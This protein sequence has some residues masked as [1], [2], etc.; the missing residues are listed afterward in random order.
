M[1][2]VDHKKMDR[3]ARVLDLDTE[4]AKLA[5]SFLDE[6]LKSMETEDPN[7]MIPC[8]C[9]GEFWPAKDVDVWGYCPDGRGE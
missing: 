5:H 6:Q 3:M 4:Q 9:C 8:S 1:S 7:E 2:N